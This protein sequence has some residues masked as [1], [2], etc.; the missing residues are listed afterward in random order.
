MFLVPLFALIIAWLALGEAI[1]MHIVIG[2][3]IS[4]IAVYF[5]NKN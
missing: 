1:E 4:L 3:M 5:I 2:G